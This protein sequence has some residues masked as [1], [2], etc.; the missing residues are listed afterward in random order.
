MYLNRGS[1]FK[2]R[3]R[4]GKSA[5][6]TKSTAVVNAEGAILATSKVLRKVLHAS[7]TQH[8]HESPYF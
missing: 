4:A 5:I 2:D 6:T 7:Q 8:F 3:S 1:G